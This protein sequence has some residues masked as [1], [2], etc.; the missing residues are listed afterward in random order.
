MTKPQTNRWI[1]AV[2]AIA[3]AT[4][5]AIVQAQNPPKQKSE[6]HVKESEVPAVALAALK[7]LAG[8]AKLNEFEEEIENGVK[9][10]EA[11]WNGPNGEMEAEVTENGDVIEIEEHVSLSQIPQAVRAQA[12]KQAGKDAKVHFEKKT[13]FMYEIEFRKDGKGHEMLVSP[14]G[15][16]LHEEEDD[17]GEEEGDDDDAEG[18][19]D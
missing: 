19:D 9:V 10:Y 7:K 12:E 14:D 18:E 13:Y 5:F 4:S 8:D 2:G 15:R 6:R 17:D 3:V 1:I 11:E 16:T